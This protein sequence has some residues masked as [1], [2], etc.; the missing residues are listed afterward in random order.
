MSGRFDKLFKRVK[1]VNEKS[2]PFAMLLCTGDFFADGENSE[3]LPYKSEKI[4]GKTTI[5]IP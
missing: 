5:Y 4:K 1:K 3:W 2:G